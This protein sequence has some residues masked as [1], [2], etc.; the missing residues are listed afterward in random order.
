MHQYTAQQIDRFK[1]T[2]V[3][4]VTPFNQ[5]GSIDFAS[6]EKLIEHVIAG[7]V[8]YLVSMGTTGESVTLTEQ[9]RFDII[10]F[11]AKINRKRAG[12]VAGF[13]GNN[14]AAVTASIR[15]FDFTDVDGILSNSPYYNK[16][17]QEGIYQ[18]YMAIDAVSPVPVIL[19][20]VP[21]RTSSN[22]TALTTM[23]LAND[24]RH[25]VGIKE[26]SGNFSQ[27]MELCSRL[28]ESFLVL[29]G[30]DAITLPMIS[31][32]AHGV[33]SVIANAYPAIFSNMVRF[34]L[35]DKFAKARPLHN[36]LLEITDLIFREGSPAGVKHVLSEMEICK[37]HLRLPLT[38]ISENL[39]MLLGDA[40]KEI[41]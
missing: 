3:A 28:P 2:G 24:A 20:N 32:G 23:R 1:G 40:M 41:G 4:L 15:K 7:G 17:S 14:T 29:S 30:D 39:Q 13:G 31:T 6:L 8:E 22:I 26:A 37:T 12:L 5:D 11:T 21:G 33:I 36:S 34:A 16:P 19:Y 27:I 25:V 10:R 38:N 9:E 18:H 35:D